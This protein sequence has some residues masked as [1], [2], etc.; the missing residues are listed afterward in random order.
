MNERKCSGVAA[1]PDRVLQAVDDGDPRRSDVVRRQGGSWVGSTRNSM[2]YLLTRWGLGL[3]FKVVWRPTVTG[4][5]NIPPEG[6][7]ILA[8]NHLSFSDSV[9]IPLVVPRRVRFLAKADYFEGRGVRGRLVA[10]FFRFVDAVPVNRES[11]RDSMA[12]LELAMS[13]LR[14][15][16]AFGIYP[17]GTRSRDGRLYRGR[18]GVGWLAMESG[19]PVVPV[20]VQ[21]TDKVQPVGSNMPRPHPVTV[22][23]GPAVDPGP[24]VEA[25]TAQGGAG[26]ARREITDQVMDRIA[27]MSPQPRADCYNE[28]P[29]DDEV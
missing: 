22:R 18:N 13:V 11:Q 3:I 9:V 29:S 2:G 12:S 14:N 27:A 20:A 7:V 10:A 26:R 17:E 8:S 25:V 21:G 16:H 1:G 23:F 4:L 5:E 6:A 24:W 28:R 15:G 19:A